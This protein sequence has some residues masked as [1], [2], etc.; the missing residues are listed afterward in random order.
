MVAPVKTAEMHTARLEVVPSAETSMSSPSSIL[1]TWRVQ[2]KSRGTREH[3][4]VDAD[5]SVKGTARTAGL[6][7]SGKMVMS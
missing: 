4:F 7:G 1:S 2:M 3:N 5:T 6:T